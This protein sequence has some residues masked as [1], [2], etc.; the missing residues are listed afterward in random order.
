M[1][2]NSRRALRFGPRRAT[3]ILGCLLLAI[4][5]EQPAPDGPGEFVLQR[6]WRIGDMDD[7]RYA[8][9]ELVSLG[10]G[11]DGSLYL[12]QRGVP[13]VWVFDGE[14][15]FLRKFG[16]YGNGP[17]EFQQPS[18]VGEVRDTVWVTDA[19]GSRLS[20]FDTRGRFLRSFQFVVPPTRVLDEPVGFFPLRPR[21]RLTDGTI[22]S[23]PGASPGMLP[24]RDIDAPL[25]VFDEDGDQ[26]RTLARYLLRRYQLIASY[27]NGGAALLRH[28]L[29]GSE[30]FAVDPGGAHLTL[31]LSSDDE[32]DVLIVTRIAASG[33][34]M[35]RR[36]VRVD[37]IPVTDALLD[38]LARSASQ[39]N[40]GGAITP[41]EFFS[42]YRSALEEGRPDFVP[43]AAEVLVGADGSAWIRGARD[44]S[45]SD[46]WVI[47]SPDGSLAGTLDV[48]D[49]VRLLLVSSDA[50]WAEEKDELGIPYL[51][52]YRVVRGGG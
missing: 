31:A 20:L 10:V 17:G 18:F 5:C 39:E 42:A 14:G 29:D 34:T 21:I 43:A 46:R 23:W 38:G 52:R 16:A 2:P 40:L 19:F 11:E 45:G 7:P 50:V 24:D 27:G 13:E 49:G 47:L 22:L 32:P 28:P 44:L 9:A 12:T 15:S 4:G 1:T 51:V 3:A 26:L 25:A 37:P 41:Q 48:A 35:F 8:F 36:R 30:A 33:D 6:D